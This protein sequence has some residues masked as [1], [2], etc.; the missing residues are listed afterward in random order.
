MASE[1]AN[2]TIQP[3][4]RKTAT[5]NTP[6]LDRGEAYTAYCLLKAMVGSS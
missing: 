6:V 4:S 1:A 3:H 5:V 2:N